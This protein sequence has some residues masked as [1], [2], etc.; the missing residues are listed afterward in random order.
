M[1]TVKPTYGDL[2]EG[3]D[4]DDTAQR[5][6]ELVDEAIE[7][8]VAWREA[9]V[10]LNDAYL[11]WLRQRG[12]NADVTFGGYNAARPRGARRRVLRPRAG[13]G[14]RVL[15]PADAYLEPRSAAVKEASQR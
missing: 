14:V 11:A 3:A 4:R 12:S 10:W 5:D 15:G 9:C 6:K 1:S 8:Y 2:P 7:A 13:A